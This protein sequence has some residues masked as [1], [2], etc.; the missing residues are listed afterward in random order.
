MRSG[1]SNCHVRLSSV[2]VDSPLVAQPNVLIAMNEPS[3]RTFLPTMKP[4]GFV[5]YNGEA[6]P[7]SL[8]HPAGVR[9]QALPVTRL[10]D[11]LGEPKAGNV[12]ALG[13]FLEETRAL[14]DGVI[15]QVLRRLVKTEKWLEI[16]RRALQRGREAGRLAPVAAH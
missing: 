9:M 16:D 7:G 3:L 6:L 12:V 5:L 10:A 14:P 4:G 2:P 8:D 1:T 11:E 15:D 13:A